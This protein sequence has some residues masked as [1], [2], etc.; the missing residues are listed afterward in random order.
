MPRSGSWNRKSVTGPGRLRLWVLALP[1]LVGLVCA[2]SA[3]QAATG[4]DFD[5]VLSLRGNCSTSALDEVPDPGLCPIPPGVPGVD[6]PP[7]AF[8]QPCGVATDL[9]GDI[10]V[11]SAGAGNGGGLE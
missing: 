9:H 3:A 6:H 7:K 8:E 4:H 2:S 11:A 5:P 1:M 10:Y